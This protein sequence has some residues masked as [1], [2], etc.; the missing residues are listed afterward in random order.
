[1]SYPASVGIE[2]INTCNAR[3]IF[4]PLFQGDHKMDRS[5]RPAKIMDMGL[6]ARI[7][8]E[9]AGW[10]EKPSQIFLNMDGEPL[11]DP[12]FCDRVKVIASAGLAP[13]VSLQTNGQ[14][15][16]E[17]KAQA[18]LEA[19]LSS[20]V[21]G[22]DGATK[23]TYESHRVRCNYETVLANIRMFAALRD[24]MKAKTRITVKYVRT[25]RNVGEVQAAYDIF[26]AFLDPALDVYQDIPAIDWS[27]APTSGDESIYYI[28]RL[29]ADIKPVGCE[30]AQT[31]III[32]SDGM[33]SACCF[34]YNLD[35]SSGG[36]G[37]VATDG[38]LPV[39]NGAKRKAF[40]AALETLDVDKMPPKCRTCPFMYG[41]KAQEE[42]LPVMSDEHRN[43]CGGYG[44]TY[45]FHRTA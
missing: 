38:L 43:F 3:C 29:K 23:Q 44:F 39:W 20:I 13:V 9:I 31:Q 15:M 4:C 27:N 14:L 6:Y 8:G 18:I 2:T 11:S 24:R 36:L 16:D 7:V 10:P 33:V 45:N 1:M 26:T 12:H 35:V 22:F 32:L 34:D 28:Q 42:P 25:K 21:F 37:N 40:C 41:C 19:G 5:V 17:A 30:M